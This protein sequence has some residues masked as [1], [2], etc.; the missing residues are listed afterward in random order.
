MNYVNQALF[1]EVLQHNVITTLFQNDERLR[2]GKFNMPIFADNSIKLL[3]KSFKNLKKMKYDI[4]IVP[5]CIN[6][7]RVFEASNLSNEMISGKF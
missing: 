1:Q 5:V 4:R 3:L 7:D 6:Y 2:S